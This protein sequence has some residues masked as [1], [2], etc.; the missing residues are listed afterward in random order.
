[1]RG[2]EEGDRHHH[3]PTGGHRYGRW[4]SPTTPQEI[5]HTGP[6]AQVGAK[7][8]PWQTPMSWQ[9]G[10]SRAIAQL[11]KNLDTRR[12][13]NE[14]TTKHQSGNGDTLGQAPLHPHIQVSTAVRGGALA[15]K[16]PTHNH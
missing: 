8:S 7:L 10:G 14:E 5:P 3:T 16:G 11:T 12:D 9:E 6:T 2:A 4:D 1:M 15:R 13:R